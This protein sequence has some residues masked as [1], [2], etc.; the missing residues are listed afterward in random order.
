[1]N[2]YIVMEVYIWINA[3]DFWTHA[4]K[5]ILKLGSTFTIFLNYKFWDRDI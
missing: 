1:M 2:K 5:V 3:N 4:S